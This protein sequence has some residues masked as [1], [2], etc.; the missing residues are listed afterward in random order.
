MLMSAFRVAFITI[1]KD[2]A[3]DLSRKLVENKLAA[4]VNIVDNIQSVFD[5]DGNVKV[6]SESLMIAKT[7]SMKIEKLIKYVRENHPYDTP[8]I[9]AFDVS[10]GNPDYLNWIHEG[11]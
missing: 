3:E 2:K 7:A 6:S 11:T 1:P 10:E 8:E 9:I 5:Q 4:C